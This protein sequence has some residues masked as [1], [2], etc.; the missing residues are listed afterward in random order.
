MHPAKGLRAWDAARLLA[1]EV[2]AAVSKFPSGAKYGIAEQLIDAV[3][4]IGANIAEG[5]A[6]ATTAA[7]L[8]FYHHALCSTSEVAHHLRETFDAKLL[9]VKTY[10]RLDELTSVTHKLIAA[11]I[12]REQAADERRSR[13]P[14]GSARRSSRRRG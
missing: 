7:K 8:N 4:S 10:R 11:L 14:R 6:Q 2:R 9:P 5:S 1:S 12:R 3:G 13:T